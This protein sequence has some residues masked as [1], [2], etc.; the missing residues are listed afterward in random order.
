M[1]Y[2]L[3][4]LRTDI[5]QFGFLIFS[6]IFKKRLFLAIFCPGIYREYPG[7]VLIFISIVILTF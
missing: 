5:G 2:K 6:A 1:I 3:Q 7:S 4:K